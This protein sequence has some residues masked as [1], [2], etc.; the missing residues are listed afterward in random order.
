MNRTEKIAEIM[1]INSR[2]ITDLLGL[3]C[4]IEGTRLVTEV[5][6]Q[7]GVQAEPLVVQLSA[8][9]DNY[10][11]KVELVGRLP[12]T[13]EE[14]EAW[15]KEGCWSVGCGFM[16]ERTADGSHLQRDKKRWAG[17]LIAVVGNEEKYGFDLT[18]EQI[19]RPQHG[20]KL[21]PLFFE[22]EDSFLSGRREALMAVDQEGRGPALVIY[23]SEPAKMTYLETGGWNRKREMRP[24]IEEMVRR[25]RAGLRG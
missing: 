3:D 9:N 12:D 19:S 4:C 13:H 17:H 6:R 18:A 1:T 25:V 14:R 2:L 24:L 23:K 21:G 11:K 15:F 10:V 22:A 8:W 16:I 20:V 7:F 5:Y